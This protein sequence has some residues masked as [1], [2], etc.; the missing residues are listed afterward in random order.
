MVK[1]Y[2]HVIT[3]PSAWTVNDLENDKNWDM[4]L[5]DA[6][7]D[8]LLQAL[9]RV[10]KQGLLSTPEQKYITGRFKNAPLGVMQVAA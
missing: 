8:D 6:Q 10:K 4:T 1:F 3:E 5:Q 9:E 7:I 2:R